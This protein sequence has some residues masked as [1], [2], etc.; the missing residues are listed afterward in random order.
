MAHKPARPRKRAAP[1]AAAVPDSEVP[2]ILSPDIDVDVT[3]PDTGETVT[4]TLRELRFRESLS[5]WAL[6][7][8]LIAALADLI[9]VGEPVG[10][11][12]AQ[13]PAPPG[14]VAVDAIL[15]D[16]GETWLR[17]AALACD[18]APDWLAR[19]GEADAAAVSQAMWTAN[20]GVF[21]RRIAAQAQGPAWIGAILQST[22]PSASGA[23]SASSPQT[24][25]ETPAS[26]RKH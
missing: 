8:P 10:A 18:R 9:P 17:L 5:A 13:T 7:A 24:A 1:K 21:I 19:L 11:G 15:G 23:S 22:G 14:A 2:A 20:M 16:H 6:A 4:L 3:D 25:T 26:S 12:D